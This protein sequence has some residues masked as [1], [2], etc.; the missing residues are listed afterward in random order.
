M[1]QWCR[2]SFVVAVGLMVTA[3]AC[4]I[5]PQPEPPGDNSDLGGTSGKAGS[6][7]GTAGTGG[8][9]GTGGMSGA[10]GTDR[11]A[12]LPGIDASGT[13]GQSGCDAGQFACGN[14]DCCAC[15]GDADCESCDAGCTEA[16]CPDADCADADCP[17][18]ER[19]APSDH[20]VD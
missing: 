13:G 3:G 14:G 9:A 5:N 18:A 15:E 16:G 2:C 12:A 1:G 7:G 6:G 4:V 20:V 11:D 17:D 19:D 10:G 8:A